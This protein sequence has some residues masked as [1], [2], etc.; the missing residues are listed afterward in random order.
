VRL[1]LAAAQLGDDDPA[2]AEVIRKLGDEIDATIEEVRSFARGV[3]PSLLA[4]TGLGE[5]LRSAGRS[6]ALPTTVHADGLGRYPRELETTAY[7]FCSE[8]LQNAAK[9]GRGATGVTISLS[10]ARDELHFEVRDDGAGFDVQATPVGTGLSN[11]RERLASVG[12]TMT[13]RSTPGRGTSIEG[14]IPLP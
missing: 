9:H 1:E 6:S 11:L 10:A 5:A 4:H 14:S 13:I 7:F 8:A 12:G 3:Y 2:R